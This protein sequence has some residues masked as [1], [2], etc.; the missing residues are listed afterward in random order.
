[1]INLVVISNMFIL[2]KHILF[3]QNIVIFVEQINMK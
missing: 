2:K 3:F 1:M